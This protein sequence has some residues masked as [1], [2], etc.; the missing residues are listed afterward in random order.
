VQAEVE[1]H[2]M[3]EVCIA[4]VM[5]SEFTDR[6]RRGSNIR[7]GTVDRRLLDRYVESHDL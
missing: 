7:M 4:K 5:L 2:V 1:A 3:H 6:I